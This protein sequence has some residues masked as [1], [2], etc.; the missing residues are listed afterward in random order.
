MSDG[1]LTHHEIYGTE[2]WPDL[3]DVLDEALAEG[4]S[5]KPSDIYWVDS[6]GFVIDGMEASEWIASM[7]MS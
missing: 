4:L 5:V 1:V 7:T 2:M 6:T 3:V